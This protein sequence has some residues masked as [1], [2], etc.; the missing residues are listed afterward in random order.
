MNASN[1]RFPD[2]KVAFEVIAQDGSLVHKG[3]YRLSD[4]TERRAFGERCHK[5]IHDGYEIRTRKATLPGA[6]S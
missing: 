2:I 4:D 5:A 6:Q 3:S 1:N